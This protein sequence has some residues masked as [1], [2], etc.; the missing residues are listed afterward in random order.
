VNE[1]PSRRA[2]L[3]TLAGAAAGFAAFPARSVFS[4]GPPP[5]RRDGQPTGREHVAMADLV[6]QFNRQYQVPSTS[7]AI[8]RNGQFVFDQAFGIEDKKELQQS[9]I[10]TMYR[11]A[12]LSKAITAVAI[13]V[14]VEKGA[15]NLSQ[16]VFG[17][18]NLF[19][20]KYGGPP[21]P[22]Y[23]TDVTVDNL[24]TNT[25]GGWANGPTDASNP[26]YQHNGW[27]QTKLIAETLKNSPLM[28]PPGQTW[29]YSDFGYCVLGRVIEQVSGQPYA[30]FV[31][32]NVLAPCGITGMYIGGNS[33]HQRGPNEAIYIGQYSEKPYSLNVTRLDSTCGWVASPSQLVQ[34]LN[35]I[36]GNGEI[37]SILKPETIRAMTTPTPAYTAD[38]PGKWA[39]GWMVTADG[40][41][42]LSGSMAG[43]TSTMTR[44]ANGL[45]WAALASSRTEPYNE[46]EA[47]M[48]QMMWQMTSIPGWTS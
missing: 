21:Y 6:R 37:P 5:Q 7:V 34:F 48:D 15:L 14:L 28:S 9:G 22:Q 4:A 47:A 41:W 13:F 35:H 46:I 36:G 18:G 38:T 29:A 1:T 8:S 20:D 27:D 25:S 31:Q 17:A 10:S 33:E 11:I 32:A 19:G 39:R 24:L 30:D 43:S 2:L 45:C 3:K 12:D 26:M 40:T 23:V 42:S 44:T 16:K